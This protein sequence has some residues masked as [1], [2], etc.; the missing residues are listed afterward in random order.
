MQTEETAPPA[1][2]APTRRQ[3]RVRSVLRSSLVRYLTVGGLSFAVDAGL[4]VALRE[5]ADA[6]LLVAATVAF[7]VALVVNFTLN[8]LWAFGGHQAVTVSF[9][10]YLTLVGVNYAATLGVLALGTALGVNYVL[11]KAFATGMT[12]LWNFV[13]YRFWVFR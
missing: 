3:R 4:L 5:G 9:A 13:A 6:P 7:W 12:V 10:K 8:R 11:V 1:A 2:V